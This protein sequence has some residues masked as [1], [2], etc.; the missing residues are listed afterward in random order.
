MQTWAVSG[1]GLT[2]SKSSATR[3]QRLCGKS[4]WSS[5]F[6]CWERNKGLPWSCFKVSSKCDVFPMVHFWKVEVSA[7]APIVAVCFFKQNAWECL[8]SAAELQHSYYSSDQ[9]NIF[10]PRPCFKMPGRSTAWALNTKCLKFMT[11]KSESQ[12]EGR[13]I[14]V[15]QEHHIYSKGILKPLKMLAFSKERSM[16]PAWSLAGRNCPSNSF[17]D[18]LFQCYSPWLRIDCTWQV[19]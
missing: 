14:L 19:S 9:Q 13:A 11:L 17:Q 4:V 5:I 3:Q 16:F 15:L 12:S 18:M 8:T 7:L 1:Q 2:F 10:T 6:H